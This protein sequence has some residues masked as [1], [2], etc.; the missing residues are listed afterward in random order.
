MRKA[1]RTT[2][3]DG[4]AGARDL[5]ER[6]TRYPAGRGP[7][8]VTFD[9]EEAAR[10]KREDPTRVVGPPSYERPPIGRIKR[11]IVGEHGA[12]LASTWPRQVEVD[13]A[14]QEYEVGGLS[15]WRR[16]SG[17]GRLVDL[18]GAVA[19]AVTMNGYEW[20]GRL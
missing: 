7:A 20:G 16:R 15:Y 2:V 6:W 13:E 19:G 3:E 4:P 17:L 18:F 1:A 12:A 10:W 14:G 8:E 11:A 5:R 9:K